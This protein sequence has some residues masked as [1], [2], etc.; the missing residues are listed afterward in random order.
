MLMCSLFFAC[1][2]IAGQNNVLYGASL[3]SR[4][5]DMHSWRLRAG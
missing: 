2:K 3:S 5:F 4:Q 1:G